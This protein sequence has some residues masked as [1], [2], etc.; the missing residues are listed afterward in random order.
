[1]TSCHVKYSDL[2]DL[3]WKC[4]ET[5]KNSKHDYVI[6]QLKSKYSLSEDEENSLRTQ[7]ITTFF[8]NFNT[9]WNEV[10]RKKDRF[11]HKNTAFLQKDFIF[12]LSQPSTSQLQTSNEKELD[13]I[14]NNDQSN[15]SNKVKRGRPRLSYEEGSSKTKKRRSAEL[16][17]NYSREELME[18]LK[19]S[20]KDLIRQPNSESSSSI[21]I[22]QSVNVNK[23][24]AMYVDLDLSKAKYEK[25]RLHNKDIHGN[26]I[27]P[28]YKL[29][30]K[31]KNDCFPDHIHTTSCGSKVN[32]ISILDHTL[33][34]ILSTL[35]PEILEKLSEKKLVFLVKWGMDGASDQQTTRQKWFNQN[36]NVSDQSS[37]SSDSDN[38]EICLDHSDAS[39]LMTTLVPLQITAN[40]TV[41]WTNVKPSS[42]SYCRPINFKFIKETPEAV[43]KNYNYYMNILDKVKLYNFTFKG[44][45]FEVKFDLWCS[46]LDGKENNILTEHSATKCCNICKVGPKYINNIEYLQTLSCNTNCYK[47]G[48]P[49]LHSWIRFMEYVLHVSY[50]LDFKKGSAM[51]Q[52]KN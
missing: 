6:S 44:M 48:F 18:A 3:L 47:F 25:L 31:A 12:D 20:E 24:L 14:D 41:L 38:E 35:N 21:N 17:K 40:D 42:V 22:I 1:M 13:N 51:G 29:L 36:Q 5:D 16:S 19:I 49:I 23:S 50:N 52:T 37:D 26:Q 46:M 33:Q 15:E 32:I 9:K 30:T 28:H 4:K 34:R 11:I 27:Y 7:L 39:V 2:C 10:C 45:T 8:P 43:K